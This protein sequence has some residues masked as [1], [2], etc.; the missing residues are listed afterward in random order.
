MDKSHPAKH[1]KEEAHLASS[2]DVRRLFR[3]LDDHTVVSVL[4]LKPTVAQLEEAV[5]RTSGAG[6]IF[7]DL[8]PAEGVVEEIIELVGMEEEEF[9]ERQ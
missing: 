8:R 7:A 5:T 9:D 2:E 4:A 6:D 1:A 3:H